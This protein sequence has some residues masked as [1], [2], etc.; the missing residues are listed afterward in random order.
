MRV[1][2]RSTQAVPSAPLICQYG[3]YISKK[4]LKPGPKTMY[5]IKLSAWNVIFFNNKS[6]SVSTTFKHRIEFTIFRESLP[7]LSQKL[8]I[9]I[10]LRHGTYLCFCCE[11][12]PFFTTQALKLH[13]EAFN[14]CQIYNCRGRRTIFS[15]TIFRMIFFRHGWL[16]ATTYEFT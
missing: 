16:W 3:G 14:L 15:S 2:G 6:H 13:T 1:Q 11:T 9:I 10:E 8:S 4:I 7:L 12:R 5:L